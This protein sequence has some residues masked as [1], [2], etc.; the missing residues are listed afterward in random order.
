[1]EKPIFI[2]G[3]HRTGSTLWH[4]IVA[5]SPEICRLTEIRFLAPR[6][7][8]KDVAYLIRTRLGSL[9]TDAKVERMVEMFFSRMGY[10]GLEGAYWRFENYEHI[11]DDPEFRR[12]FTTRIKKSDRSLG[13]IFKALI[14]EITRAAGKTRPCVKFPLDV[15]HVPQLLAWYPDCKVMH[16]TRDPRAMA[17]SRTNDP[18]GTAIRAGRHAYLSSGIRK[19]A[20]LI[21][22]MQYVWSSRL[23][24]GYQSLPNYKLFRYEDLLYNPEEVIRDLCSF[25]ELEFSP[26]MLQPQKGRHE[27][28]PSSIT[29]KRQ[30]EFDREAAWRWRNV[31]SRSDAC[32]IGLL[33]KRSMQRLAYHPAK[34]LT[35]S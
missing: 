1:M 9:D 25:L 20:I 14:D 35:G 34:Y 4:N 5:M 26:E 15:G 18:S 2:V 17:T 21:A 7:W 8:Q 32:M 22:V 16:I 29:G 6:W 28:Q 13:S 11:V 31:I 12:N 27:H 33:T 30:K 23:H 3:L 24:V 10:P 19:A